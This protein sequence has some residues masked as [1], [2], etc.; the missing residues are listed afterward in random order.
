MNVSSAPTSGTSDTSYPS[1]VFGRRRSRPLTN[2]KRRLIAEDL[3]CL[4]VD[5]SSPPPKDLSNLFGSSVTSYRLEI[6]FG[7]G[8]H[9][10]AQALA[11]R[12]VG[13]FGVE[14]FIDGISK[15]LSDIREHELTNIRIFDDDATLFL[16]WLPDDCLSR[17]DLLYPDPWHK[18]RHWKR[19]L[20]SELNLEKFARVLLPNG[21]FRFASDI[22]DYVNWTLRHFGC[23]ERFDW[24]ASS[25]RDWREAW[26]DWHPTRY[27]MKAKR[28]G[29]IPCYLE[30]IYSSSPHGHVS[31]ADR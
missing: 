25:S 13:F 31:G 5:L 14:P 22:E 6:G 9:L 21:I 3:P 24:T 18:R 17:I 29:R 28:A 20:V 15:L 27:E 30:F 16:D 8:E 1:N 10:S 2:R 12:D 11:H 26:A 7:G 23:S 4:L 19:R